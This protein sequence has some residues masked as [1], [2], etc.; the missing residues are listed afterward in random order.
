MHLLLLVSYHQGSLPIFE[1][2]QHEDEH[3]SRER[4]ANDDFCNVEN[5]MLEVSGRDRGGLIGCASGK[6]A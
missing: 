3:H 6:L 1:H 4:D 2:F 5:D